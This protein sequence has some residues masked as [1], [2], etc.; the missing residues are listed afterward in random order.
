MNT[1][2]SILIIVGWIGIVLI[3]A[4]KCKAIWPE[5][6]ELSR[7]I[8]HIGTG[9]VIPLAW[10]LDIS[11]NIAIPIAMFI[12]CALLINF[13]WRIIP[14][15]EDISRKSIGTIAYGL[16]IS[17]LLIIFWNNNPLAVCSG[18]LV[19]AFGD[20]LAGLIGYTI[21]SPSWL[22]FGQ[23][24]SIA[25]TTTMIFMSS[26]ILI[27]TTFCSGGELHSLPILGIALL[28][29]LLEQIGPW[30]IDNITVPIGIGFAWTWM[31]GL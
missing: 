6:K 29:T 3:S 30:G 12:T 25:G 1:I 2:K 31:V 26:I 15:I 16:S 24:K 21:Q 14:T 23:K 10:W 9:P 13:K 11:A 19:M 27:L 18:V 4:I 7:K 22:I 28:A 5:Q 8:V 17:I 20:G